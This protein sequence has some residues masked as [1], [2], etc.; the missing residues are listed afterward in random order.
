MKITD[1]SFL[2]DDLAGSEAIMGP[3]IH[4][5]LKIAQA[6]SK[7]RTMIKNKKLIGQN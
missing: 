6:A 4:S 3:N 7:S 5:E 2:F 1:A